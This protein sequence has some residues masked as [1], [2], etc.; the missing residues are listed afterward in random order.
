MYGKSIGQLLVQVQEAGGTVAVVFA[1]SGNQ[2]NAW[3][4]ATIDL[5][6]YSGRVVQ[7]FFDASRGDAWQG[8]IAIDSLLLDIGNVGGDPLPVT[9]TTTSTVM[10]VPEDGKDLLL[11]AVT[12]ATAC[13]ESLQRVSE[14]RT[15]ADSAFF[16]I[17]AADFIHRAWIQK[18]QPLGQSSIED[19]II[20]YDFSSSKTLAER[21]TDAT[22]KGEPC[23]WTIS[24]KGN[25]HTKSGTYWFS[26]AADLSGK[27]SSLG[28][29]LSSDDGA[30]GAGSDHVNGNCHP[31][32]EGIR[33]CP[34]DFWGIMNLN[35]RDNKCANV[36]MGDIRSYIAYSTLRNLMYL[37]PLEGLNPTSTTTTTTTVQTS[38]TCLSSTCAL[39]RFET[40]DL[41]TRT[42][43]GLWSNTVGDSFDWTRNWFGQGTPS[44]GTGPQMAYDGDRFLYTEC[45]T[46]R[47][48]GDWARLSSRI[49]QFGTG[50]SLSFLYHMR[51]SHMGTVRAQIL[52]DGDQ[53]PVLLW[54]TS[55]DQGNAWRQ[56]DVDLSAYSGRK[57]QL[58][59]DASCGN[60]FR[61]DAA[62]DA[63]LLEAGAGGGVIN[64]ASASATVSLLNESI[65]ETS[66]SSTIEQRGPP[67]SVLGAVLFEVGQGTAGILRSPEGSTALEE[68]L[69]AM[70]GSPADVVAVC[71]ASDSIDDRCAEIMQVAT[72][73]SSHG[74][75][76]HVDFRIN[77][78]FD[79]VANVTNVLATVQQLESGSEMALSEFASE[80]EATFARLD[81]PVQILNVLQTPQPPQTDGDSMS[82]SSSDSSGDTDGGGDDVVGLVIGIISATVLVLFGLV[83]G[84]LLMR[85]VSS[86]KAER[87]R[88][89][90]ADDASA[91]GP[92]NALVLP[93][94]ATCTPR[95]IMKVAPVCDESDSP[96]NEDT[97]QFADGEEMSKRDVDA[98]DTQY[99]GEGPIG[100]DSCAD[101]STFTS[102]LHHE[103]TWTGSTTASHTELDKVPKIA[104]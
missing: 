46:P 38:P 51:G 41:G 73:L 37:E 56:A 44:S 98:A 86:R 47:Q 39:C 23:T 61:S 48:P 21:L 7:V 26:D 4:S 90:H 62:I 33:R 85:F 100:A 95:D 89:S 2:G 96:H 59:F 91:D 45:S 1:K 30:W 77:F 58:W 69:T 6:G 49:L 60:G 55:G 71:F 102:S 92:P 54:E 97:Q 9:A 68:A 5:S 31:S 43:C 64:V 14:L 22:T 16:S 101:L 36:H 87:K 34:S 53:Q 42:Y 28:S 74:S 40:F 80:F 25:I 57:A 94:Q 52:M 63:V 24:Y 8:D 88:K 3:K 10:G 81:I 15:A 84:V 13:A 29:S 35:G 11:F 67:V 78:E 93:E 65:G 76:V 66:P 27:L 72:T 19:I 70:F 104:L 99:V 17:A 20:R 18:V 50:A 12:Q 75:F 32:F 83:C 103:G 82:T 79:G